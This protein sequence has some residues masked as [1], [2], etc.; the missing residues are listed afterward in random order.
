MATISSSWCRNDKDCTVNQSCL[1]P[2][3]RSENETDSS[4]L[5]LV[6]RKNA[7]S[8]LFVGQPDLI[9][10]SVHVSDYVPRTF[11]GPQFINWIDHL[12]RY[13]VSFS[14]GLAVL[15]VVPCMYMDGQHIVSALSEIVL[16][17]RSISMK[18]KILRAF[19]FVGTTLVVINLTFG[20]LAIF[21]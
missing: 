17:G 2:S 4:S 14:A 18:R 1:I 11:L 5:I 19:I 6:K 15:N 12:L 13:I 10:M 16:E 20:M 3:F 8:I 7:D 21:L 9:Y